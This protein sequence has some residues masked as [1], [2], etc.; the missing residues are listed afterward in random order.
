MAERTAEFAL[1]LIGGI[2]GIVV[3]HGFFFLGAFISAFG[4]PATVL[5]WGIGGII[6]SVIGL[7]GAAFA[8]SHLGPG[9]V[10]MLVSGILG[11]FVALGLWI[12]ALLLLVAGIIALIRKEKPSAR[13]PTTVQATFYCANCGQQLPANSVFCPRCGTRQG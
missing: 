6:F 1:G 11:L 3:A 12:G 9:G 4:G 8:K 7:I 5:A 10:T 13:S 2:L